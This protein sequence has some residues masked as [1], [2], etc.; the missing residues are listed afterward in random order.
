MGPKVKIKPKGSTKVKSINQSSPSS[1]K[2]QS[3]LSAQKPGSQTQAESSTQKSPAELSTQLIISGTSQKTYP[4]DYAMAIPTLQAFQDQGLTKLPSQS[5][6]QIFGEEPDDLPKN[7]KDIISSLAQSKVTLHPRQSGKQIASQTQPISQKK[8]SIYHVKDSFLPTVQMEPEFWDSNPSKV[9]SKVFPSGFLFKPNHINKTQRFYEFILVDS[10]SVEIKHHI[11]KSDS[12]NITHST[13]QIL[14]LL[15]FKDFKNNQILKFSQPFDPIGYNYWDYQAAWTNVFWLSNKTGKHSWLIYFK[16]NVRYHFP[17]WFSNWWDSFGP[18]QKILPDPVLEGFN[19]FKTR[20]GNETPFHVSLHFFSKFSLAWIFAWQHQFRKD[21]SSKLLPVLGKQLSVKWWDNFD[22]TH[23]NAQGVSS[24]FKKN[25]K[26][27]KLADPETSQ[28]LNRKA[29]IAAAIAASAND[30]TLAQNLHQ[31]LGLLQT[32]SEGSSSK[33]KT[34]KTSKASSS[35]SSGSY[36]QN[37]DMCF[38]M[39]LEGS[40]EEEVVSE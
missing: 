20:F 31:I 40:E 16:K 33:G 14:K 11:D 39:D 25:P 19:Q 37:E 23:A 22:A 34:K 29:Q 35:S 24:W 38:G 13:I 6:K 8:P 5:W 4:S 12:E 10:K 7:L 21:Q 9:C 1:K 18:I 32:D 26:A 27:L 28:F 15:S 30:E 17:Q 36:F 3:G 2:D